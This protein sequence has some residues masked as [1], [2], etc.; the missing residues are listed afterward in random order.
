MELPNWSDR[1]IERENTFTVLQNKDGTKT[2]IPVTGEVYEQGT[3][4]NSVNLNKLNTA[5]ES[6]DENKLNK[7]TLVKG[8][9]GFDWRIVKFEDSKYVTA[10]KYVDITRAGWHKLEL[11]LKLETEFGYS[12]TL[13]GSDGVIIPFLT[14]PSY[15]E[16][17]ISIYIGDN[18]DRYWRFRVM[19]NGFYIEN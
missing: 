19:V 12:I 15:E 7:P 18:S 5:I 11:P 14:E 8:Q 17:S 6:L 4:L 1:R 16:N 3:P 9:A 2:L 13:S 10:W